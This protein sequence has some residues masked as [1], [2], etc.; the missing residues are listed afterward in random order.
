MPP[1]GAV[2]LLEAG[3]ERAEAELVGASVLE[4]FRDGM[5]PEE[6]AVL[7]RG[8][9]ATELFAQVFESYGSRSPPSAARRSPRPGSAPG[10]SRSL[11]PHSP[12]APP[13]TSSPGCARPASSRPAP[14]HEL[15]DRLEVQVRRHEAR[16]AAD[17]RWH[18]AKLGGR[19]LTELDELAAGRRREPFLGALLAEAESIWTAPH[20]RRA[21]VLS[22]DDEAAARA[23]RE[24]A[25]P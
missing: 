5:A 7:V 13:T 14:R 19:E 17:A 9:A 25:R 8:R 1:N 6:I 21:D 16:T 10:S 4:L 3:G 18:W 12:A 24:L 23:A 20:T 15:A 2:R 11:A 22:A